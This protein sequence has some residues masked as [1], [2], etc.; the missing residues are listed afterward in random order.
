[1]PALKGILR[2]VARQVGTLQERIFAGLSAPEAS[3]FLLLF[4]A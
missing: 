1:M 4:T 2:D 3:K